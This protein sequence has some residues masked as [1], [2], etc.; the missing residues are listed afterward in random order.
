MAK[1]FRLVDAA[2][3][4]YCTVFV[5]KYTGSMNLRTAS[6]QVYLFNVRMFWMSLQSKKVD[7]EEKK[8]SKIKC[9][10]VKIIIKII[11]LAHYWLQYS[12][13]S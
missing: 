7:E 12:A 9:P 10:A 8:W 5:H 3:F 11:G 1:M 2:E 13:F 6:S 4:L